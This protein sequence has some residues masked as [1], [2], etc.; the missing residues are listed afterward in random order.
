MAERVIHNAVH[1]DRLGLLR[2]QLEVLIDENLH[3]AD[4][5]KRVDYTYG[6]GL[7][8]LAAGAQETKR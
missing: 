4:G 8:G 1:V 6:L 3:P 5:G 2:A 7:E